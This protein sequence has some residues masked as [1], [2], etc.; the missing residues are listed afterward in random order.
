MDLAFGKHP[1]EDKLAQ[2]PADMKFSEHWELSEGLVLCLGFGCPPKQ[3][4]RTHR[5]PHPVPVIFQYTSIS[6]IKPLTALLSEAFI[7]KVILFSL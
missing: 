5:P 3:Q 4:N 7:S 6:I 2:H 1:P